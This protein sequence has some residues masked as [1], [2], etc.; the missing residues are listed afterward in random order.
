MDGDWDGE[1]GGHEE[2]ELAGAGVDRDHPKVMGCQ[3]SQ[4]SIEGAVEEQRGRAQA[5]HRSRVG[6]AVMGIRVWSQAVCWSSI[7]SVMISVKRGVCQSSIGSV[8]SS[9]RE[10]CLLEQHRVCHEQHWWS[11]AQEQHW[12]CCWGQQ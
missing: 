9:T 5:V 2:W 12:V 6:R 11:Q 7:G 3:G 4:S 1:A 8:T 10:V